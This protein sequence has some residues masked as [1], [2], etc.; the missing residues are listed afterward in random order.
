[1]KKVIN[2]IKEFNWKLWL[3]I[4]LTALI[5]AVYKTVRFYFLGDLPGSSGVDIASQ[6]SW[7]NLLYEI[8]EEA[9]I[10]PSFFLLGKSFSSKEEMS[11]KIRTGLLISFCSYLFL[12]ILILIF[13][14][15]L[16]EFMASDKSTLIETVR[17]IRLETVGSCISILIKFIIVVFVTIGKDKYMY[18]LLGVQ[19]AL[20]ILVDT[21]FLSSLSV[22]LKLGV[23]GI[24]Y[25]NMIV[26]G[27]LFIFS[28]ILLKKENIHIFTKEKLSFKWM[29][30]YGKLALF[31]GLESLVR[32]IAFMLMIS[33]LVNVISE[34]GT[35]WM[36][37]NFIWTWLLLPTTALFDVVKKEI[38][39]SKDNIKTKIPGYLL[40]ATIFTAVWFATI[41]LWNPFVKYVLNCNNADTI[42]HVV[43]IQSGFYVAYIFNCVFDGVIYGRGR[44]DLMLI[45]SSITNGTYYVLMF[46][47]WK[48]GVFVPSLTSIALMFGIGNVIDLIPTLF[49]FFVTI[50]KEGISLRKAIN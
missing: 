13:A 19:T 47:L 31:S 6:L 20:S 42:V 26:Q 48:T 41:P 2:Y 44:T 17:Y 27:V 49:T 36:A 11:N 29:N 21:F 34:Q 16:C 4:A 50:K 14:P 8:I 1:M 15:Q 39:E 5:P 38:A 12:S 25:S 24:A 28:A 30:E 9:F 3:V 7:V 10:L 33:R 23:D 32:N 22:S 45:Q 46:I 43:L 40:V 37:N 35:Y 18:A